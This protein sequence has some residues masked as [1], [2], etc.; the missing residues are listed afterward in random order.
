M[1]RLATTAATPAA[2]SAAQRTFNKLTAQIE[3]QRVVL[4]GWSEYANRFQQRI[5]GEYA[6]ALKK[7]RTAQRGVLLQLDAILHRPTRGERLHK[8]WQDALRVLVRS[9]ARDVLSDGAD[10]VISDILARNSDFAP[11]VGSRKKRAR[12]TPSPFEDEKAQDDSQAESPNTAEPEPTAREQ[13]AAER[14]RQAE[15]QSKQS[16]REVFRKLVSSLHP[17]RETDPSE[18]ARKT[19]LMKRAN[20]AYQNNDLLSLLGMQLELA[21]LDAA[22]LTALPDARLK[23]FNQV[24]REQLQ[25]LKLE[26]SE[27]IASYHEMLSAPL[28]TRTKRPSDV[29]WLINQRIAEIRQMCQLLMQDIAALANPARRRS[30]IEAM[31][32]EAFGG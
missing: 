30:T 24:L 32:A 7:M 23:Q 11:T 25:T 10:P 18:H 13:K 20:V 27:R 14:K 19:E 4:A 2:L 9:I 1:S 8:T 15:Q 6:P 21:Q 12:P 17:D 28:G 31:L 22:T 26:L 5:S 29:D 16:V 3:A